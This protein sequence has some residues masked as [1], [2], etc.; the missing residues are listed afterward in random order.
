MSLEDFITKP[1][2]LIDESGY[3]QDFKEEMLRD[4]LVFGLNSDKVRKDAI[5]LGNKLTFQHI[6]D[7]A[8]TEES[9]TAQM[10]EITQGN[11]EIKVKET[12]SVRR[13]LYGKY[14]SFSKTTE[15][16]K[17]PREATGTQQVQNQEKNRPRKFKF[18]YST[19]GCFRCGGNHEGYHAQLSTQHADFAE[20]K[21]T[22]PHG[23]HEQKCKT[24]ARNCR[25]PRLQGTRDAP[26]TR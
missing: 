1:K 11:R 26:T 10:K 18:K 17:T 13:G 5:A 24:A 2:G 20:K 21:R 14:G 7:L 4:T 15:C 19:S 12:H 16:P 3:H 9:T 6:Y 8:K 23:I 25:Q 22:F